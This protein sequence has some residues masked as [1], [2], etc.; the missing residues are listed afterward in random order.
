MNRMEEVAKIFGLELG[1]EF[2]IVGDMDKE[3]YEEYN[4]HKFTSRGIE[5]CKG[6][7]NYIDLVEIVT[8]VYGINKIDK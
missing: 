4:P 5:D 8:G 6:F 7:I 2:N 1:E 3:F